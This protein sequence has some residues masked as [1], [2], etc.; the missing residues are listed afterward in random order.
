MVGEL[1]GSW[2][3]VGSSLAWSRLEAGD[4]EQSIFFV[5]GQAGSRYAGRCINGE[6]EE[7]YCS[8]FCWNPPPK[9]AVLKHMLGSNRHIF[10]R[11]N[12]NIFATPTSKKEM[13]PHT[14]LF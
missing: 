3:V 7:E 12:Y 13:K 14:E 11:K 5:F 2:Q 4:L 10:P 8:R 1:N 6:S 9:A